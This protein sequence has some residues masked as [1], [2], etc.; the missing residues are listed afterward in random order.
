MKTAPIIRKSPAAGLIWLW[1]AQERS[2]AAARH[3][4]HPAVRQRKQLNDLPG[5]AALEAGTRGRPAIR[6]SAHQG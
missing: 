4:R 2:G 3:R 1:R 5:A 6:R